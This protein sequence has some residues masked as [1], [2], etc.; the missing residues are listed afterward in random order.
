MLD[1][2][3]NIIKF[4]KKIHHNPY[5]KEFSTGVD[6]FFYR[7]IIKI[8]W[9]VYKLKYYKQLSNTKKYIE[10]YKK[11]VG[12]N[13]KSVFVFA[14]GPSLKDIDLKKIDYLCKSKKFDLI[15]VNSYLSKSAH[16]AKPTFAVFGDNVHFTGK[17]DQYG[18]DISTCKDLNI[19]YFLPAKYHGITNG[20][21]FSFCGISNLLSRNTSDITKPVGF[22]GVTAFFALAL[23]KMLQYENIYICGFDNSYFKDFQVKENGDMVILHEHYY[24]DKSQ[25][26]E[27]PCLYKSTSEFFFDTYRHFFYLEKIFFEQKNMKNI[28]K[29]TYLSSV[30]INDSLDVYK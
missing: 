1:F 24:D 18:K 26:I 25:N 10:N 8:I 28:A 4:F 30:S 20:T 23:A 7:F 3:M 12:R 29:K 9:I 16:I 14:N 13:K 19:P 22:Y 6:I 21:R 27:V 5:K 15:C 11:D 2:I 17:D